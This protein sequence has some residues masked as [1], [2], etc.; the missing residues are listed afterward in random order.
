MSIAQPPKTAVEQMRRC[1]ACGLEYAFE[2]RAWRC[3][4][5]GA[6]QLSIHADLVTVSSASGLWRFA[7]NRVL[8]PGE[9]VVSLGEGATPVVP[10]G[11]GPGRMYAKLEYLAPTGSFKD[12]GAA[13]SVTRLAAIGVRAIV[14]DS[15]GNAGVSLAAYAA[16]AGIDC[17]IYAAANAPSR[18]AQ[19]CGFGAT[20]VQVADRVAATQAALT[21]AAYYAGHAWDPFFIEGIKMIAFELVEQLA[22]DPPARIIFPLGQGTLLLGLVRGYRELLAAGHIRSMP[23]LIAVQSDACAPL[24]IMLRDGRTTLPMISRPSPVFADGIAVA[25]P[26]RWQEI[27]ETARG[28][29]VTVIAA[30]DTAIPDALRRLG[31]CGLFVEPTSAVVLAG[32]DQLSADAATDDASTVLILTAT[33]L[34]TVAPPPVG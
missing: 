15:A 16:A 29:E 22:H 32:F 20:L 27:T 19:I 21:A 30:P 14:D 18:L 3:R 24:Q 26:V 33:G 7:G 17:T 12:R 10:I 28:G 9:K 11:I 4:C 2:D 25:A 31:R 1:P 23:Q 6:L 8:R 13:T 34:K 5:G